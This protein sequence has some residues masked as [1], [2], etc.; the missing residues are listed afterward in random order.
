[1]KVKKHKKKYPLSKYWMVLGLILIIVIGVGLFL[2]FNPFIQRPELEQPVIEHLAYNKP[3]LLKQY[4]TLDLKPD[5]K[6]MKYQPRQFSAGVKADSYPQNTLKVTDPGKYNGW[7][8][9]TTLQEE[10]TSQLDFNRPATV[11]VVWRGESPI[12]SWLTSWRADKPVLINGKSYATYRKLITQSSLQLKTSG[13]SLFLFAEQNGDPSVPPTAP[14]NV[15]IPQPNQPCPAWVHDEYKARAPDGK[16]YPTWHPQIDPV[17]WCYFN[18]EH[19]SDPALFDKNFRI[20]FGYAGNAMGMHEAHVGYKVYVWDDKRGHIWLALQHQGTA[21]NQAA[22]G[23]MHELDIAAKDKKTNEIVSE[24]YFVGDYGIS[25]PIVTTDKIKPT[26]CPNEPSINPQN[27]GARFLP[28][29][30]H[31]AIMGEPWTVN[32]QNVIGFDLADFTVNTFDS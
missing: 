15:A 4:T 12:P 18:H 22:C 8:F 26:K 31:G 7:D 6:D 29:K 32:K 1:M 30:D 21:T 27:V 16:L 10:K 17:Y 20:P 5:Y 14:A 2:I 11:I 28:V 3:T 19:G 9:L 25:R 13:A 23:T 24:Q